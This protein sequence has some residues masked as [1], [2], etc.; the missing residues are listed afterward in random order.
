M[1]W[2]L[3]SLLAP[4]ERSRFDTFVRSLRFFSKTSFPKKASVFEVTLRREGH[5]DVWKEWLDE[6]TSSKIAPLSPTL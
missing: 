6:D 5:K 4:E 3:G 2:S 1:V